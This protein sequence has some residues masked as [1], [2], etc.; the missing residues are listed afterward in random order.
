LK[1]LDFSCRPEQVVLPLSKD[2]HS[3]IPGATQKWT[4]T[5]NQRL[6]ELVFSKL[7]TVF[8]PDELP[9]GEILADLGRHLATARCSAGT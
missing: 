7:G 4:A 8:T 1:A 6:V 5:E 9:T 3:L 2:A